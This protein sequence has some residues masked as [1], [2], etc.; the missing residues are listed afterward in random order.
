MN[1][2]IVGGFLVLSALVAGAAIWYLQEYG[3]YAEV[4][5]SA[6]E[7]AITLTGLDGVAEPLVTAGFRGIDAGSSPLR[8][9]ACFTTPVSLATLT[10]TF[11]I[12]DHP[13][14]LIGPRWFD[15]FDA[16]RLT[17]DLETGAAVAFLGKAGIH[18]GVDRV[19]AIY[20]DGRA[21][22]WH[23]LDGGGDE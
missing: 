1:G 11:R 16:G 12:Y 21:F 4:P 13:T 19:V 5:A 8:F 17:E 23:Q 7:A 3:Y 18:P 14:P 22:A 20:P 6:P 9:R 2:R 10:E 15:C